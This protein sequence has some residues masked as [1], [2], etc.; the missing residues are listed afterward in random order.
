MNILE[1]YRRAVNRV[2]D[3]VTVYLW[4]EPRVGETFVWEPYADVCVGEKIALRRPQGGIPQVQ[5][6]I[7]GWAVAVRNCGKGQW[8]FRRIK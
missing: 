4:K 5:I 7:Y 1:Q 3:P 8:Q 6:P 2:K